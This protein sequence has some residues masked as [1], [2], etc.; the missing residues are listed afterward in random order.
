MLGC[1]DSHYAFPET[2][3]HKCKNL[4]VTFLEN[5]SVSTALT[6][7]PA[8]SLPLSLSL[9]ITLVH[10]WP[11]FICLSSIYLPQGALICYVHV[12]TICMR[13][14]SHSSRA[15]L[16]SEQNSDTVWL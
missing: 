5:F 7:S 11:I 14:G 16:V 8:L 10:S 2:K 1:L 9:S 15:E 12:L 4:C 6:H 3:Y 13:L